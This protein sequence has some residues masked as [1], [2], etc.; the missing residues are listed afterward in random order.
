MGVMGAF[1]LVVTCFI[2]ISLMSV[3]LTGVGDTITN[4]SSMESSIVT[5]TSNFV[6]GTSQ[7]LF[8]PLAMLLIGGLIVVIILTFFSRTR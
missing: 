3:M 6:A 4:K 7:I 1:V 5:N 8:R 2:G